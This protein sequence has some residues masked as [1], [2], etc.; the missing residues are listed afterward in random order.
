MPNRPSRLLELY[1]QKIRENHSDQV[2][3]QLAWRSIKGEMLDRIY[4]SGVPPSVTESERPIAVSDHE[5]VALMRQQGSDKGWRP[6]KKNLPKELRSFHH[7]WDMETLNNSSMGVAIISAD[8]FAW[9]GGLSLGESLDMAMDRLSAQ[10]TAPKAINQLNILAQRLA[11]GDI[12]VSEARALILGREKGGG[13]ISATSEHLLIAPATDSLIFSLD[14]SKKTPI[15]VHLAAVHD[16]NS[17]SSS[18]RL[19]C[20]D[21]AND[22]LAEQN[23]LQRKKALSIIEAY[24]SAGE[25]N[26]FSGSTAD[27]LDHVLRTTGQSMMIIEGAQGM[28]SILRQIKASYKTDPF[29]WR[30][31]QS[32]APDIHQLIGYAERGLILDDSMPGKLLVKGAGIK[33]DA[34]VLCLDALVERSATI[35]MDL[36][37]GLDTLNQWA[38]HPDLHVKRLAVP[39]ERRYLFEIEQKE[40][41]KRSVLKWMP[42]AEPMHLDAFDRVYEGVQAYHFKG[43]NSDPDQTYALLEFLGGEHGLMDFVSKN[44]IDIQ[45]SSSSTPSDRSFDAD[46]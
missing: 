28:T 13:Y 42:S 46:L 9:G 19:V 17:F 45:P 12:S 37:A 33:G 10:M 7:H 29:D 26:P 31:L 1:L 23:L 41:L 38:S 3:D 5:Y 25:D 15:P 27:L 35:T 21:E 36:S 22:P 43:R 2:L 18:A 32:F 24:A 11:M 34:M 40:S 14:Q 6:T 39:G 20:T 16:H 8:G 4:G 44:E 30:L